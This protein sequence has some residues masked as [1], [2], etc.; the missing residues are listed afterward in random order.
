MPALITVRLATCSFSSSA[1]RVI[2]MIRERTHSLPLIYL[3]DLHSNI[4]QS[5]TYVLCMKY[6]CN[7]SIDLPFSLRASF[8]AFIYSSLATTV[9]R[10]LTVR[11]KVIRQL[12]VNAWTVF[13]EEGGVPRKPTTADFSSALKYWMTYKGSNQWSGRAWK[14]GWMEGRRS[15]QGNTPQ[16]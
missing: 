15:P 4:N 14:E 12:V 10:V 6:S 13:Y 3:R 1:H 2:Q 8:I 9:F 11:V 7:S 5:T 16:G